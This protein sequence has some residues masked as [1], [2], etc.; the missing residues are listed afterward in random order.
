MDD[1]SR[2]V[3]PGDQSLNPLDVRGVTERVAPYT[4]VRTNRP[5]LQNSYSI[6]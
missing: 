5:Q 2:L 1:G 4:R 6:Y 3:A